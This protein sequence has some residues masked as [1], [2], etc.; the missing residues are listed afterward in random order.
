[1]SI[2][3]TKILPPAL[4]DEFRLPYSVWN[5]CETLMDRTMGHFQ[6]SEWV[7]HPCIHIHWAGGLPPGGEGAT[8]NYGCAYWYQG[9]GYIR[10]PIRVWKDLF[11]MWGLFP[12]DGGDDPKYNANQIRIASPCSGNWNFQ[13]SSQKTGG[14]EGRRVIQVWW[15]GP[16][17]AAD[18]VEFVKQIPL[19]F[20][21]E[22]TVYTDV[23]PADME[24]RA[25][26]T[27]GYFQ[28]RDNKEWINPYERWE[29]TYYNQIS[30]VCQ[31][32]GDFITSDWAAEALLIPNTLYFNNRKYTFT[33]PDHTWVTFNK[34]Y[35]EFK[36]MV[37][38]PRIENWR[39]YAYKE[40]EG[41]PETVELKYNVTPSS[42]LPG[43]GENLI[44]LQLIEYETWYVPQDAEIYQMDTPLNDQNGLLTRPTW[45][46]QVA[47][48]WSVGMN[49]YTAGPPRF[50]P[51]D[52]ADG[53][54]M[55]AR[56]LLSI[57]SLDFVLDLGTNVSYTPP[58]EDTLAYNPIQTSATTAT[59][60]A[61]DPLNSN[62]PSTTGCNFPTYAVRYPELM[63]IYGVNLKGYIEDYLLRGAAAGRDCRPDL[64][65]WS[66]NAYRDR[67]KQQLAQIPYRGIF[68]QKYTLS[69]MP[70]AFGSTISLLAAFK[71]GSPPRQTPP[72]VRNGH[73]TR[74][75]PNYKV[76]PCV[77][78]DTGHFAFGTPARLEIQTSIVLNTAR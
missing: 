7:G 10:R 8:A 39:I 4:S 57:F 30:L 71:I 13:A 2:P 29:Y 61:K 34:V 19:T 64:K 16:I 27:H 32:S 38:P 36:V 66:A 26:V 59:N 14:R 72:V 75:A 54:L 65:V 52:P 78:C 70:R 45:A 42:D 69:R 20:E 18:W 41:A 1:M 31:A 15:E 63:D 25:G 43:Y 55:F 51:K 67:Y 53:A 9:V 24:V 44:K 60:D 76:L 3:F 73:W 58:P 50:I 46:G 74:I 21:W 28:L 77:H 35:G 6:E 47:G 49:G 17:P 22:G 11:G 33:K 68:W 48:K 37:K 62:L 56:V 12:I 5:V 40:L 23:L